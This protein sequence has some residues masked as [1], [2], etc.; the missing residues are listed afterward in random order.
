MNYPSANASTNVYDPDWKTPVVEEIVLG[1]DKQLT[2]DI[3][4][5]VNGYLK[6]EKCDTVVYRYEGTPA[7]L[8]G[9]VALGSDLFQG[10]D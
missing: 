5:G 2:Q 8:Q 3:S 9:A 7:Q 4:V 10:R 6:R 1:Y